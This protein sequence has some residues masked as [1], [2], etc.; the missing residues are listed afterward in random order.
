MREGIA[1]R[2]LRDILTL[3]PC[4]CWLPSSVVT[5][6][7]TTL[8]CTI[9]TAPPLT[10]LVEVEA[11]CVVA[12]DALEEGVAVLGRAKARLDHLAWRVQKRGDN[13]YRTCERGEPMVLPTHCRFLFRHMAWRAAMRRTP[14][15][16][17]APPPAGPRDAAPSPPLLHAL[18]GARLR[19]VPR[20]P[21]HRLDA[22]Q[23]ILRP[24]VGHIRAAPPLPPQHTLNS[25]QLSSTLCELQSS[26]SHE[27][28]STA[29]MQRSASSGRQ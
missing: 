5:T 3:V 26:P 12:G 1:I 29:S 15:S 8:T 24:A 28:P 11:V 4:L 27:S 9:Q 23:R 6:T 19:T 20:E 13:M 22:A 2:A 10:D 17:P 14:L 21:A 7:P 25:T 16:D 18:R